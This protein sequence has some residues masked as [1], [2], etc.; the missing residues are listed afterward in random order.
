[1]ILL[2]LNRRSEPP[3]TIS[4]ELCPTDAPRAIAVTLV[5]RPVP[6]PSQTDTVLMLQLLQSLDTYWRHVGR[7]CEG[8]LLGKELVGCREMSLVSGLPLSPLL[9]VL[10]YWSLTALQPPLVFCPWVVYG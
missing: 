5:S 1:M 4:T 8:F 2:D 3:G 7:F 10:T 6:P 9:G